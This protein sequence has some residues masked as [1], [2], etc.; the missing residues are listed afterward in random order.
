MDFDLDTGFLKIKIPVLTE[1]MNPF[2]NMQGGMIAAA[3]DNTLGPLSMAV[4]PPN[5]TRHFEIKYRRA[6]PLETG[7]LY[8]TATLTGQRKQQLFFSAT[9]ADDEGN[10]FATA[11]S[12]HWVIE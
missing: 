12:T 2:G 8:V 11:K 6:I 5:F 9:V 3:I 10:E 7:Y 1:H 4:A